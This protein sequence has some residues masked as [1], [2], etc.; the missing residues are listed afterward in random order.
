MRFWTINMRLSGL[1]GSLE[2]LGA[3]SRLLVA[4]AV[5]LPLA[6][7]SG[8]PSMDSLNPTTWF[9]EKYQTKLEPDLPPDMLYDR[10]LANLQK[11]DYEA[12]GKTFN[13]L[14]KRNSF[15]QWQRK[16]LLMATFSQYQDGK[17]DDAIGTA[18]RYITLYPNSPDT[19]YVYYLEAMSYYNLI[20]DVTRDQERADKAAGLFA[21]IVDK[22]PKSEY[23]EDARYKL[24][25]TRDQLAGKEMEVGR[26]YLRDRNYT[27]AINR[28]RVVLA[29]YQTT[30]HAE[31][32]LMRLVEA[33]LALGIVN[34]AQTAAAVLG[35]NFPDSQWY[36]DAFSRLK[37]NGASPEEDK[38]SWISK[39]FRKI[40]VG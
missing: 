3:S 9:A 34:E 35:H 39:A 8:V 26:Y 40:G 2:C 17:F 23:A 5:A 32:A 11:K 30:R 24:Q 21:T 19:P 14:E 27:A 25:I 12:A 7:C 31:E 33:Y 22:Y 6:A 20:P 36:K 18:Q 10:G 29:K 13:D 38:N 15:S 28:F 4:L 1:P 16:G 37:E